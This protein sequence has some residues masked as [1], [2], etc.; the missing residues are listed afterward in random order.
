MN[1]NLVAQTSQER[2]LPISKRTVTKNG[3]TM[4]SNNRTILS[5]KSLFTAGTVLLLTACA[6]S[7]YPYAV[8]I[9]PQYPTT[10]IPTTSVGASHFP[11]SEIEF[12]EFDMSQPG[13]MNQ[14]T[15]TVK[16]ETRSTAPA[17][18]MPSGRYS[19]WHTDGHSSTSGSSNTQSS[20]G[21][22]TQEDRSDRDNGSSTVRRSSCNGSSQTKSSSKTKSHSSGV[23]FSVDG[24]VGAVLGMMQQMESMNRADEAR[25]EEMFKAFGL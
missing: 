14:T 12:P 17:V 16:R 11:V 25:A 20:G 22:V 9:D 24:P 8:V 4:R 10:S 5:V 6:S 18:I 15:T 2:E 21:C 23:G 3:K 13:G 7:P 19:E 1:K